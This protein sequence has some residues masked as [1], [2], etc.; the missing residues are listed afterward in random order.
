[1]KYF[2]LNADEAVILGDNLETDIRGNLNENHD[3][4]TDQTVP[5]PVKL[6]F[7]VL[8]TFHNDLLLNLTG[9]ACAISIS[10]S[11]KKYGYTGFSRRRNFAGDKYAGA[12]VR[13]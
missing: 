4:V 7:E 1:M 8:R 6:Y 13:V 12:E 9:S 2:Q 5:I 11:E 10:I 3:T